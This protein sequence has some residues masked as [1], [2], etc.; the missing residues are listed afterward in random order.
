MRDRQRGDRHLWPDVDDRRSGPL[1]VPSRDLNPVEV[2]EVRGEADS[3]ALTLRHHDAKTHARGRA[4]RRRGAGRLQRRRTR[5]LRGPGRAAHVTGVR[6][7]LSAALDR[8][9]R[10]QRLRPTSDTNHED[11][12]VVRGR[13]PAGAREIL[14]GSSPPQGGGARSSTCGGRDDRRTRAGLDLDASWAGCIEDQ[15]SFSPHRPGAHSSSGYR[16]RRIHGW[17]SRKT[18]RAK[19]HDEDEDQGDSEGCRGRGR[20]HAVER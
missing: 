13:R 15:E 11:A 5:P 7:N 20:R 8:R 6:A 17:T 16:R 9:C 1:P 19:A 18:P 12:P 4:G 3:L 10:R 14:T 2:S